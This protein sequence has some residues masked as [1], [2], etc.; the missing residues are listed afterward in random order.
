MARDMYKTAWSIPSSS[1][2]TGDLVVHGFAIYV[3]GPLS[4]TGSVGVKTRDG[5]DVQFTNVPSGSIIPI[6]HQLIYGITATTA[7]TARNIISLI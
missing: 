3:G 2:P 5:Q 4:G 1:G 7:T 6:H